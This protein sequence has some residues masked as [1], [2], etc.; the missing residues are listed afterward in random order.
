MEIAQWIPWEIANQEI[1][2]TISISSYEKKNIQ[3]NWQDWTPQVSSIKSTFSPAAISISLDQKGILLNYGT[4]ESSPSLKIEIGEFDLDQTVY[5]DF[6]GNKIGIRIKAHCDPFQ[7][8]L[9]SLLV[10]LS[11]PFVQQGKFFLP[12]VQDVKISYGSSPSVSAVRCYGPL[13]FEQRVTTLVLET[14]KN[15]SFL[16]AF[17]KS[18]INK[19]S[20]E[21][22]QS[23][24]QNWMKS[25][26]QNLQLL[27]NSSAFEHGLYLKF[28]LPYPGSQGSE[29]FELPPEYLRDEPDQPEKVQTLISNESLQKIFS[30]KVS[31]QK[32]VNY[33]LQNIP[34]FSSFMNNR[35]IQLFVWSDLLHYSRK[36]PF[37][38]NT[39]EVS[40]L[41]L[42]PVADGQWNV[43]MV[44]NG[45]VMSERKGK[46]WRFLEWSMGISS[47]MGLNIQEGKAIVSTENSVSNLSFSY[48]AEYEAAF[49]P[50]KPSAKTIKKALQSALA[51]K[52]FEIELPS[53]LL[54]ES[55]WKM[56]SWS[57]SG[58][59]VFIHWVP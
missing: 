24:F 59:K 29:N 48:G 31:Q 9:G 34:S 39:E 16:E 43:Q 49:D 13:G 6:G 53:L 54:N 50:G 33:N 36:A 4:V 57:Q 28:L 38:L 8:N 52:S 11:A 22:L 21:K 51:Q 47:R 45:N 30:E 40:S 56:Q 37:Y 23:Q 58:E 1:A 26:N 20:A 12:K 41:N 15:T 5:R 32:L 10:S 42:Q 2:K 55:I 14:L 46:G 27:E 35:F 7:V 17:I 25:K 18:E 19:I 44:I 3:L